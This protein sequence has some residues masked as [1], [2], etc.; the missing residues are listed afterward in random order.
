MVSTILNLLFLF[1]FLFSQ[2]YQ[3]PLSS[4][5]LFFVEKNEKCPAIALKSLFSKQE[6]L[7]GNIFLVYNY[8]EIYNFTGN[9]YFF[10]KAKKN[11][12]CLAENLEKINDSDPLIKA[13]YNLAL[14]NYMLKTGDPSNLPVFRNISSNETFTKI[15]E[16]R[17]LV[18]EFLLFNNTKSLEEA[19]ALSEEVA[20]SVDTTYK[21]LDLMRAR[22]ELFN[23]KRIKKGVE[24]LSDDVEINYSYNILKFED[25]PFI[26]DNFKYVLALDECNKMLNIKKIENSI[27]NRLIFLGLFTHPIEG[28][29]CENIICKRTLSLNSELLTLFIKYDV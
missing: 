28:G 10:L 3:D 7:I 15:R 4:K 14:L 6:D 25:F 18:R 27:K 24:I 12:N 13:T 1:N 11:L 29:I 22:C 21:S 26:L 17:F 8:A 16:M 23:A 19:E 5:L 2:F 20:K 9:Q